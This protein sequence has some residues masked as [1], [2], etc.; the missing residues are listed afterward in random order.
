MYQSGTFQG[1]QRNWIALTKEAYAI[2]MYFQKMV[3]YLEDAHVKIRCDHAPQIRCDHAPLHKFVYSVTN[4]DKINNW[5]QEI[6]AITP[7]IYFEHI[8]GRDNILEESLSRL[9]TLGI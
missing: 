1:T 7:Y 9:K 4:N 3:C 2:Y 6:H 5:L 8:K